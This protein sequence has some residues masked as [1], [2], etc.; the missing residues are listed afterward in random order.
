VT[1]QKY[2]TD[3]EMDDTAGTI[4]HL[5]KR[6]AIAEQERDTLAAKVAEYEARLKGRVAV[7][8]TFVGDSHNGY[9]CTISKRMKLYWI[10]NGLTH[11]KAAAGLQRIIDEV[12]AVA[13]LRAKEDVNHGNDNG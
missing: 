7:P 12:E 13:N 1:E 5:V 2:L 8:V 4:V 3:K 11:D 6:A 9:D 10:G